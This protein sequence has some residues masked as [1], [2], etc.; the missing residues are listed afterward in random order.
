MKLQIV[1]DIT[2]SMDIWIQSL[3]KNLFEIIQLSSLIGFTEF[4]IVTYRDY[5]RKDL[6]W[7][8]SYNLNN[9]DNMI[10]D[11]KDLHDG[12][13][14]GFCEAFKTAL[15]S[16]FTNN[17]YLIH[18]TDSTPHNDEKFTELPICNYGINQLK[19][20]MPTLEEYNR[21]KHCKLDR[22]GMR[23]K[24]NL[25]E[26]FKIEN[27][28]KLCRD[29]NIKIININTMVD[30][31][32]I[33][34][35]KET[36]GEVYILKEFNENIILD[37]ILS[38]TSE[39]YEE[40]MNKEIEINS[41]TIAIIKNVI[42]K[43]IMLLTRNVILG[44]VWRKML[45]LNDIQ[46][47]KLFEYHKNKSNDKEI[48]DNWLNNSYNDTDLVR[49]AILSESFTQIVSYHKD[50]NDKFEQHR[51]HKLINSCDNTNLVIMK[52]LFSRLTIRKG[53][54][55][56][57]H[58]VPLHNNDILFSIL[59]HAICPGTYIT[60]IN[61]KANIALLARKSVLKTYCTE[62][63]QSVKGQWLIIKKD[64]TID[65]I[66]MLDQNKDILTDD[67]IDTVNKIKMLNEYYNL[68]KA[69]VNI[70]YYTDKSWDGYRLDKKFKCTLCNNDRPMSMITLDNK[71]MYCKHNIECHDT[72]EVNMAKCVCGVLYARDIVTVVD[73]KNK[74]FGCTNNVQ[75]PT[76]TCNQCK[77]K[78]VSYRPYDKCANCEDGHMFKLSTFSRRVK[79]YQILKPMDIVRF[80]GYECNALT[81]LYQMYK[82]SKVYTGFNNVVMKYRKYDILNTIDIYKQLTDYINQGFY[83]YDCCD[84]CGKENNL[85]NSCGLPKCDTRLCDSCAKSWYGENRKGHVIN[86]RKMTCMFCNREPLY[87]II[88]KYG[89]DNIQDVQ[90]LP[91]IDNNIIYAW[92]IECNGIKECGNRE[93]GAEMPTFTNYTCTDCIEK[94]ADTSKFIKNC[95]N[96]EHPTYLVS[97]CSHITCICGTHWCFVCGNAYTSGTIYDHMTREHGGWW[98]NRAY[99]GDDG[100]YNDGNV[101]NE[102]DD[103]D[104]DYY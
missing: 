99:D 43:N 46:L 2:G 14:G 45:M 8:Q 72:V 32:G 21:S 69:L 82:T 85:T 53:R 75:V 28:I 74:C 31:V 26:L 80:L 40:F 37:V 27:I 48:I 11:I 25:K 39:H 88:K 93:C 49:Q 94:K 79:L 65:Y 67:E 54:A 103:Y 92:C 17:V 36:D 30:Y 58:E 70:E 63:L 90:K 41:R 7:A 61:H 68:K 3:K 42:K 77:E 34:L 38:W 62:Y 98:H 96:C 50:I 78:Y 73:G 59:L 86:L 89:S 95:P 5:D 101:Y 55:L 35:S 97:G 44:K 87:K 13:G 12:G 64:V 20:S 83:D 52:Q 6:L 19:D 9:V 4:G 33:K 51:M 60:N 57:K 100:F 24:R 1:L 91:I 10:N 22:E 18:I 104:D 66:R 16:C 102:D 56:K 47:I 29:Q 71:C 76:V 15:T 84:I 23:E 81:S